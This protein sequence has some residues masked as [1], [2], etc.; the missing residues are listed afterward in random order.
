MGAAKRR[1]VER[2]SRPLVLKVAMRWVLVCGSL[3]FP[4]CGSPSGAPADGGGGGSVSG[5]LLG[6]LFT[7][8]DVDCYD[9]KDGLNYVIMRD[10][11]G[12]V[13]LGNAIKAN[14][15]VIVF[16][17]GSA[18][19]GSTYESAPVDF[20]AFDDVCNQVAHE[21]GSGTVTVSA[22]SASSVSGTFLDQVGR[23]HG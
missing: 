18:T 20:L 23:G 12:S 2:F 15:S 22:A 21:S 5:T 19:A 14:S 8:K 7:A 9:C 11:A 10:G 13:C 6:K 17:F 3:C 1:F 4:A 16:N